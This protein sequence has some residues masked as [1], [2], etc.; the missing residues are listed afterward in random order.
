MNTIGDVADRTCSTGLPGKEFA[1]VPAYRPCNSL[2]PLA[3]RESLSAS[4]VMQNG[5]RRSCD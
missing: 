3:A 1:N 5:S 2:T 4:T